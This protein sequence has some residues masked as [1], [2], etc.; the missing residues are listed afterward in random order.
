MAVHVPLSLEA[1]AEARL[2]M[3]SANNLL[4]PASGRSIV[5]P[6]QDIILGVYYLTDVRDGLM[7]EGNYFSGIEDVLIALDH[8]VVHL[9][10]RIRLKKQPEWTIESDDEKWFETSPGRVLFNSIL[11]EKLRFIN[12]QFGKK[13]IGKLIDDAYD[14][15][16]RSEIVRILDDIKTLGYHWSTVSGISFGVQSIIIPPE[17]DEITAETIDDDEDLK[18]EYEMGILTQDEYLYRKEMLWSEASRKISE[19]ILVHMERDNPIRMMVDS[20]A[21]GSKSQMGQ[22]AGI[23]G[24][25]SD[26]SG[27]IIDYPLQPTSVKA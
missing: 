23:R 4:S 21:R 8:K 27:R 7:G 2:L 25:M 9:N 5:T 16:S 19:N 1:Q 10:A 24:L 11:P 18:S 12:K 14:V 13:A 15:I 3:L 26:P 17:K 20:G 22:M 6:T